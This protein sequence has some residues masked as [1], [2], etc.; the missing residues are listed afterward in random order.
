MMQSRK[1]MANALAFRIESELMLQQRAASYVTHIGYSNDG[2]TVL[3]N[4]VYE[5]ERC[6]PELKARWVDGPDDVASMATYPGEDSP[7]FD[8]VGDRWIAR[9]KST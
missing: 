1:I 2:G 3:G 4:A 9:R 5:I 7:T 6:W 8:L